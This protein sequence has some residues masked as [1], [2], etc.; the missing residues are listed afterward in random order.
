MFADFLQNLPTFYIAFLVAILFETS[1]GLEG[2]Q[3]LMIA[4]CSWIL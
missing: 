1:V 4:Y 3:N 2:Y